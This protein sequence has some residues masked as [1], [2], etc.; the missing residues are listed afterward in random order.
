MG[1]AG[2]CGDRTR[3][4]RLG[5]SARN[6]MLVA[7]DGRVRLGRAAHELVEH[8]RGRKEPD[9]LLQRNRLLRLLRLCRRLGLAVVGLLL[10][11]LLRW[12]RLRRDLA[13]KEQHSVN[14]ARRMM[15]DID[16]DSRSRRKTV[17]VDNKN[18]CTRRHEV[19]ATWTDCNPTL[20]E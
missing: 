9:R 20:H 10:G 1:R 12:H 3:D 17:R 8:R 4:L 15:P 2:A 6:S 11:W 19:A 16:L 14:A 5:L 7:D 13:S 18:A